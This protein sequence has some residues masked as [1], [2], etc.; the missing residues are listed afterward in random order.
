MSASP[1]VGE[2]VVP[3]LVDDVGGY[4]GETVGH[5]TAALEADQAP[6]AREAGAV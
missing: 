6:S 3:Y 2:P 1:P 4:A 5:A